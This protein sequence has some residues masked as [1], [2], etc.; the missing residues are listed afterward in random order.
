VNYE[1]TQCSL[2]ASR[3]CYIKRPRLR[4]VITK[5]LFGDHDVQVELFGEHLHINTLRE[6]GYL[7]A[8]RKVGNSSLLRDEIATMLT[9]SNLLQP[10]DTFVDCGAN[11]GIYSCVLVRR[12]LK[13]EGAPP[14][15]FYAYEPHPD[16]FKRLAKNAAASG[17]TARNFALS[18]CNKILEFVDGAVSH[19]FTRVE[20]RNAY[21][22]QT[23]R[24]QV[25]AVR[26]DEQVIEG[27]SIVLKIDVEGQE[28]SVIHGAEGLFTAG[29]I[30][31]VY[32]D[33]YRDKVPIE[34]FLRDYGFSLLDLTMMETVTTHTSKL[35]AIHPRKC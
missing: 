9:L 1:D 24:V 4:R 30:K 19:V 33:G 6:N 21:N 3:R 2:L 25:P 23:M 20:C 31:A 22:L 17:V 28:W 34:T 12:V 29:R 11:I 14:V 32:C 16:T 10:G 8:A 5:F 35:L 27:D 13:N 7:R 18:D 26:L 15:R